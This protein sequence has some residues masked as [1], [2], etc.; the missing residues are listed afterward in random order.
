M[1]RKGKKDT[2]P[3]SILEEE[4]MQSPFRTI[5][6]HLC[7]NKVAMGSAI[8]FI[9]IFLMCFILPIWMKQD[10][11]FQDPTQKNIAPGFSFL[12]VPKELKNN[13]K[14]IE[15]GPTFGIGIDNDG[16]VYEWG[17]LT[18]RLKQIPADMGKSSRY[19][20]RTGPC[21]GH[22]RRRGTLYMGLQPDEPEP[23]SF[24]SPG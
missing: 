20:G 1:L 6:Q 12:S 13:A 11:N 7:E 16:V 14:E 3:K 22:E 4:Q 24:G 17:T 19:C 9:V 15:A 5:I 10:L 21:T 23:D 8:I 2:N 18:D